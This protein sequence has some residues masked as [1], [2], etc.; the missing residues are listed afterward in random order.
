MARMS[1][2]VE[3]RLGVSSRKLYN[4][5]AELVALAARAGESAKPS[6]IAL[7]RVGLDVLCGSY[8]DV[9]ASGPNPKGDLVEALRAVP[10]HPAI[11][12]GIRILVHAALSGEFA[13]QDGERARWVARQVPPRRGGDR[14]PAHVDDPIEL[15][16]RQWRAFAWLHRY[17][18]VYGRPP[19]LSE[20]AAGLEIEE[21]SVVGA[22]QELERHGAAANIGGMRGWIPLRSP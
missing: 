8:H 19:K 17:T 20:M 13:E 1:E 22:M 21:L 9:R 5:V 6:R 4:N 18:E 15:T 12:A 16:H 3:S 7:A 11:D 14:P 10:P 2:V